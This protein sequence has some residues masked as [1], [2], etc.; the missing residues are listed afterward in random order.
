MTPSGGGIGGGAPDVEDGEAGGL[1]CAEGAAAGAPDVKDGE[2]GGLLCAEGAA[3]GVRVYDAA[4]AAGAGAAA[5]APAS[6]AFFRLAFQAA[7][8]SWQSPCAT[9]FFLHF[10]WWQVS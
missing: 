9:T 7:K 3:A 1:L 6:F 5:G 8:C 2:A 4:G 10:S